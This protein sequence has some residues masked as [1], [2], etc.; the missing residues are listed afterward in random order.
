M[1][2]RDTY[3]LT[4]EPVGDTYRGLVRAAAQ[5]CT[6][7][8]LVHQRRERT[9]EVDRVL[10]TLAPHLI[11]VKQGSSWPGSEVSAGYTAEVFTYRLVD[12]T[13]EALVTMVDRLY[14]WEQM[15][16]PEDL[17]FLRPDGTVWLG[18]TAHEN[19]G[20]IVLSADEYIEL[21]HRL[22]K[23]RLQRRRVN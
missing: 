16:R 20:W 8:G 5:Y 4:E 9:A 10:R 21:Q 14:G 7:F 3:D 1:P 22:P 2:W 15:D 12:A 13:V 11:D 6:A 23:L 19:D 18:T 17:H